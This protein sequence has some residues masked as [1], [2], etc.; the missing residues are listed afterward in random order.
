MNIFATPTLVRAATA[1]VL[2]AVLLAGD[3]GGTATVP[4]VTQIAGATYA[5]LG[6]AP[7]ASSGELRLGTGGSIRSRNFANT[8]N[9]NLA[10]TDAADIVTYGGIYNSG[11]VFGT[12]SA[13]SF[14]FQVNAVEKVKINSSGVTVP[15]FTTGRLVVTSTGGL[16]VDLSG[17]L[18]DAY[19]ATAAAIAGSKVAPDFA[20]QDVVTTGA[21]KAGTGPYASTGDYRLSASGS[22]RARKAD[23]SANINI[24]SVS[25]DVITY[26][27]TQNSGLVFGTATAGNLSFQ[28]NAVEKVK[29]DS[30]GLTIGAFTSGRVV[31]VSTAGLLVDTAG[32]TDA[33]IASGA[34]IA[35]SKVSPA[36]VAQNITTT[37]YAALGTNTAATGALRLANAGAIVGRNVANSADGNIVSFGA[38]DTLIFGQSTVVADMTFDVKTSGSFVWRINSAVFFTVST[39]ANGLRLGQPSLAFASTVSAPTIKVDTS[40]NNGATGTKLTILG[41]VMSGTTSTGGDLELGPGS[42]T[43]AN[44]ALR[45]INLTTTTVAPAAGAGA[46]LP[47][48]PEGYFQAYVNGTVRKLAFYPN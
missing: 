18:T 46:A 47:A 42:G 21:F 26:G 4:R 44:G 24:A 9:L 8:Q 15:G 17:G 37:G 6:T 35:G 29:L 33:H 16:L 22:I 5:A 32:L 19:V 38:S 25:S 41:Q 39:G 36:F 14:S 1:A 43:S 3:F 11:V 48:T 27:G 40:S 20:A 31:T 2:G 23:N 12:A 34:A 13:G 30:S 7:Y 10:T 28:V 45:L